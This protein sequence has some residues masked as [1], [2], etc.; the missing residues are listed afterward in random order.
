MLGEVAPFEAAGLPPVREV[1]HVYRARDLIGDEQARRGGG[2]ARGH[3]GLR[4]S[5][6][7]EGRGRTVLLVMIIM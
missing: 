4:G 1:Q 7:A 6:V 5:A 2:R 3:G